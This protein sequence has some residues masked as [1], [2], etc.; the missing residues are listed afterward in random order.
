[1]MLS[2]NKNFKTIINTEKYDLFMFFV[3]VLYCITALPGLDISGL[4]KNLI[5]IGSAPVFYL[6]CKDKNSNK[7]IFYLFA[8][9]FIIQL[10][11]WLNSLFVI[12]DVAKSYPD[13]KLL[14]SLFLFVFI[15][16]WIRNDKN[17]RIIL[18]SS[19]IISFFVTIV[20]HNFQYDSFLLALQGGRVDFNL[21]N[22]QYT[23]M[24]A[25]TSVM[26]SCLILFSIDNIKRHPFIVVLL[27]ASIVFSSF[28][29]LASQ[30]RQVWLAFT[31]L[32]LLLPAAFYKK[33]GKRVMFGSYV[34]LF[35]LFLSLINSDIVQKRFDDSRKSGDLDVAVQ[36]FNGKWDDIPM[37]SFGIRFNSW[38]EASDWVKESP[39]IGASKV[40]VKQVL[41]TS[42]RFQ[43]NPRTSGFG[44][45]HN[46]YLETLVS[47]GI[48]GLAFIACF[49]IAITKNVLTHA[50]YPTSIFFVLFLIF[51]LFINNFESYNSKYYGFYM[52]NIV[53]GALFYIP[54]PQGPVVEA[55]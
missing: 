13:V 15:S 48:V 27:I 25:A 4:F 26:I 28:V 35:V 51:W 29:F 52:Q 20:V 36:V 16:F 54:K 50:D 18:L 10:L 12:P 30:S 43:S 45:L 39:I 41:K 24:L 9:S 37:T 23:T 6:Y 34:L 49:Y 44:H 11:S 2:N 38:L 19:F 3:C 17:R 21:G 8:I 1:M 14:S 46:Y 47:F 22:A 55:A 33:L 5:L 32:L 40:A 42:E 31:M 7:S 53:L